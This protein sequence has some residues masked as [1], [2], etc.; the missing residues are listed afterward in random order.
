[1]SNKGGT[2]YVCRSYITK[3]S[4]IKSESTAH[5]SVILKD[6][7]SERGK[8]Y[9]AQYSYGIESLH[10]DTQSSFNMGTTPHHLQVLDKYL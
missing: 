2:S 8:K 1:M 10:A 9:A 4:C 6:H 7:R 3:L 5:P